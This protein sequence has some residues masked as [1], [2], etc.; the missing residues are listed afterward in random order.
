MHCPKCHFPNTKVYDSRVSQ[1]GRAMRRRRECLQCG[2]RFTTLEEVRI[3]DIKVEK[4]NGQIVDFDQDKLELG[5]RKAFNKRRVDNQKINL[6][7]QKVI[8]D[9]IA[10]GKNPIKS[11]RIGRILL[12]NLRNVDE[13]AYICYWSMFGNFETAEEFNNLLKEFQKEKD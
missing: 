8:D 9:I 2:Y 7:V 11:T 12:R 10:S 1:G 6:L 4:R 13:A 3:L 5:I